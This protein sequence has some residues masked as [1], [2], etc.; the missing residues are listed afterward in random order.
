M[1]LYHR[2]LLNRLANLEKETRKKSSSKA[3]FL[4][5]AGRINAANMKAAVRTTVSM[6]SQS[7]IKKKNFATQ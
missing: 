7:L 6:P 4:H 3:W 1:Y 2:L 5:Q